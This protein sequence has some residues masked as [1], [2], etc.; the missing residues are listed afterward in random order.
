[1]SFANVKEPCSVQSQTVEI[2]RKVRA[3]CDSLLSQQQRYLE[4]MAKFAY[5]SQRV[6]LYLIH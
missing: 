1:M 3:T 2:M 5:L 4:S 6:F